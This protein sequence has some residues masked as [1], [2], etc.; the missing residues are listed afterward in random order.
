M[1]ASA[2]RFPVAGTHPAASF[3]GRVKVYLAFRDSGL[4]VKIIDVARQSRRCLHAHSKKSKDASETIRAGQRRP[5]GATSMI[6][7]NS[8]GE[9]SSNR[10]AGALTG[11][12]ANLSSKPTF[13]HPSFGGN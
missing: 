12:D 10:Y 1:L 4:P 2:P 8:G 9:F 11:D 13:T 6:E 7:S 3:N 5:L